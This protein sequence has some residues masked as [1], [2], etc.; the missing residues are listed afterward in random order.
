M[1][2]VRA[3]FGRNRSQVKIHVALERVG[4]L[5]I[6][7]WLVNVEILNLARAVR[8]Q[9][10]GLRVGPRL[11]ASFHQQGIG[12]HRHAVRRTGRIANSRFRLLQLEA[13]QAQPSRPGV[14]RLFARV[15]VGLDLLHQI[16]ADYPQL[17]GFHAL[18]EV[19]I[20][21]LD[22][23]SVVAVN[24]WRIELH[25]HIAVRQGGFYGPGFFV[26]VDRI[27][28]IA[29]NNDFDIVARQCSLCHARPNRS[30]FP[31]LGR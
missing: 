21:L 28:V 10:L 31:G 24:R 19:F 20:K 2:S 3:I 16:V 4:Q 12:H 15:V 25:H 7:L 23:G 1:G 5:L 6:G 9:K 14:Q 18:N 30:R 8:R 11:E 17:S 26:N 27:V 22:I 29:L 13:Q